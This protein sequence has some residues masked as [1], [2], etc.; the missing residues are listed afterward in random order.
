MSQAVPVQQ[1]AAEAQPAPGP[2]DHTKKLPSFDYMTMMRQV[3]LQGGKSYWAQM[4]EMYELKLGPGKIAPV[5]Y[6]YYGLFEDTLSREQ[7]RAFV[8]T[9]LRAEVNAALLDREF[10]GIGKDKIAFYAFAAG[11]GL[12]IP[13]TRALYHPTRGLAGAARL[14]RIEALA[15]FLRDGANTPF[16]S[17]PANLTASV[18]VASV[19]RYHAEDD[20]LEMTNGARFPVMRFVEEADRYFEGGYL[21]QERLTAHAA[22]RPLAGPQLSTIRFM[23]LA[24]EGSAP[25]IL[26]ATWR[27]PSGEHAADVMWRGNMMAALNVETGVIARVVRG[28]GLDRAE[29]ETHPN[30]RAQLFGAVMPHW[31]ELCALALNAARSVPQLMLTGWDIALAE[32]GP[33]VIELEPDG[34]DP[35]V[36]Q[37]AS[38]QGL[39]DGAYGAFLERR[40]ALLRG[41]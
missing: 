15:A 13:R 41:K 19:E 31:P 8:G 6:F 40:R 5:E 37:L 18:G 3:A 4:R 23:V 33:A 26:R 27:A 12:P 11:M 22:L 38:G 17:K 34:G 24:D 1:Q 36:T 16:F 32:G 29:I 30:T 2:I 7:K 14:D 21:F 9:N 39:L 28:R 25:R 35:A 20:T 10:F